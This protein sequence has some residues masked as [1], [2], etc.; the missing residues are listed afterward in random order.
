M[1]GK[2]GPKPV[3]SDSYHKL[4]RLIRMRTYYRK[5]GNSTLAKEYDVRIKALRKKIDR[6]FEDEKEEGD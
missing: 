5:N 3:F 2:R 6:C 4:K 1:D